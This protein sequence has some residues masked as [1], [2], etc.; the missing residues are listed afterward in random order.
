MNHGGALKT[1]SCYL[2][3]SIQPSSSISLNL[4]IQIRRQCSQCFGSQ[5]SFSQKPFSFVKAANLFKSQVAWRF[6]SCP[7]VRDKIMDSERWPNTYRQNK[8][9][10]RNIVQLQNWMYPPML[11]WRCSFVINRFRPPANSGL[12]QTNRSETNVRSHL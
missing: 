8:T 11:L 2:S 4:N 7:L 9:M 3:K 1:C 12:Y 10:Q 5:P 6:T